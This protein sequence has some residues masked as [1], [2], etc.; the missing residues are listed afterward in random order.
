MIDETPESIPLPSSPDEAWLQ[1]RA[2][3]ELFGIELQPWSPSRQVAANAMGLGWPPSDE[4]AVA[5]AMGSLYPGALRDTIIV[6][7]L[8]TILN[9]SEQKED[10]RTAWNVQRATRLPQ[11]AFEAATEWAAKHDVT[12]FDNE[13]A[14]LAYRHMLATLLGVSVSEFEPQAPPEAKAAP[15]GDSPNV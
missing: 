9:A 7:W 1:A 15:G 13:N 2:G 8:R 4:M 6:T 12:G 5:I 14:V 3:A 10:A 11:E